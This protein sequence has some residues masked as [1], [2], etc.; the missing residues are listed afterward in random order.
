MNHPADGGDTPWLY[1]G[2]PQCISRCEGQMCY[3]AQAIVDRQK[4]RET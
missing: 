1:Q 2:S 3:Q 4:E